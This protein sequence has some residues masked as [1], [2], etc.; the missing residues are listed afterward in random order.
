EREFGCRPGGDFPRGGRKLFLE[1]AN[2]GGQRLLRKVAGEPAVE[3]G[4]LV[5]RQVCDPLVPGEASR[6]AAFSRR[7]P[8]VA[9][10]GRHLERRRRPAE[11]LA[12]GPGLVRPKRCAVTGLCSP[13]WA[14]PEPNGR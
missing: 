8:S 4:P 9:N 3:F 11:S 2:S 6:S 10:I 13:P 5:G 7:P 1:P 12:G 14:A